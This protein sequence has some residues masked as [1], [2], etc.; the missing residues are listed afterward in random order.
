[1]AAGNGDVN[2]ERACGACG[3]NDDMAHTIRCDDCKDWIH[4]YC[5]KL[6][7][8]QL[9]CFSKSTRKYTCE[10]CCMGKYNQD[11][12]EWTQE[13]QEAITKQSKDNLRHQTRSEDTD[14]QADP[15]VGTETVA[16]AAGGRSTPE[17]IMVETRGG[18]PSPTQARKEEEI[19]LSQT[20]RQ[21][22]RKVHTSQT[23]SQVDRAQHTTTENPAS[24]QSQ[25]LRTRPL[26]ICRY[27]KNNN[28]KYGRKGEGCS[29]DHPKPCPKLL[30]HGYEGPHGCKLGRKCPHYHPRLCRNSLR[31]RICT[32][33]KC[34]FTH[35][36]GTLRDI[37]PSETHANI[38]AR[39]QRQQVASNQNQDTAC[40]E[41]HNSSDSENF[42]EM[43]QKL[44][45]E[46]VV[47]IDTH[48]SE[49]KNQTMA[50]RGMPQPLPAGPFMARPPTMAMA[51]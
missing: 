28:C 38:S 5:S 32:N 10:K 14:T 34:K 40:Q 47:K 39:P 49:I 30:Q 18:T 35:L 11:E 26:K 20:Q 8:Y 31:D 41:K 46:L 33:Q 16:E 15:R 2:K 4:Y 1:M 29:H 12:D 3:Y 44:R 51:Y 7:I 27:Y 17:P 48:L 50:L 43:F 9:M 23:Q 37:P 25:A 6:P 21:E 13:A 19:P 45:T 22:D 24:L 42:L 36:R